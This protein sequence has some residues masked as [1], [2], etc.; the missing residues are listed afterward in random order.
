MLSR[1]DPSLLRAGAVAVI[2]AAAFGVQV[3]LPS[4][5]PGAV[6]AAEQVCSAPAGIGCGERRT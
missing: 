6:P 1:L 3:G 2:A 5:P 4:A